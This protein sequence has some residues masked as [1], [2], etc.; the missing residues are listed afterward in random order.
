[1]LAANLIRHMTF[2]CHVIL[3]AAPAD[4][5]IECSQISI[6][7]NVCPRMMKITPTI[8]AMEVHR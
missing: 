7:A 6:E 5:E 8:L 2:E 1:M 4:K 3:F